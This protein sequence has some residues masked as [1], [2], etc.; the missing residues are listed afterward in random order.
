MSDKKTMKYEGIIVPMLTPFD[1]KG[2]I[3][4]ES[5]S[6]LIQF[7]L[8]NGTT[9]FIF[10]STG[11]VY[12]ISKEER[13]ILVKALIDQ[14]EKDIPLIVGMGGLTFEDTIH[15]SNKYFDWGIDAVVITLPG[16]FE[17]RE[18]QAYSYF[19]E[20]SGKIHGNI[21]LYNIPPIAHNTISINTADKLS[22]I[23][24]I[25]GI[26]DS[27][28]NENRMIK[29]LDLWRDRE[30]FFYLVGVNQM[31]HKGLMYG[32]A[33]LVPSTANIIPAIYKKMFDLH[34]E[35]KYREVS[36]V[37]S[38][39]NEILAIYL[40]DNLMGEAITMLK[41]MASLKGLVQS[42]VL[43]PLTTLSDQQKEKVKKELEKFDLKLTNNRAAAN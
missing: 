33:G 41:Y 35:G 37:H 36:K 6:R 29:S 25:I 43:P 3:D 15:L 11:E 14:R 7:L 13:D 16:Y 5:A 17:L 24:N 26:K 21:I 31:M 19:K 23:K 40:N 38:L 2:I 12:S 18:H 22:Q 39:T 9:P 8:E 34:K 28:Y 4:T 20:I 27:E 1:E 30:D 32:A 10:G 42:Y